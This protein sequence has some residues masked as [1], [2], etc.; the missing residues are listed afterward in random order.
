MFEGEEMK[1][2]Y[3]KVSDKKLLSVFKKHGTASEVARELAEIFGVT[4]MAISC[5]AKGQT[6]R[7]V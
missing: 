1:R 3:V 2:T 7:K 4:P 6:W 5:A